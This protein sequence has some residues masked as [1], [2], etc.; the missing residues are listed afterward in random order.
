MTHANEAVLDEY[1]SAWC[2]HDVQRILNCFTDD[3][4]YEDLAFNVINKGHDDIR[5]FLETVFREQK[6]FQ[7]RYRHRFATDTDGAGEWIINTTWSGAFG[8]VDKTGTAVEFTGLS[9]YEFRD[10]KISRCIDCWDS[11]QLMRQ[12]RVLT[13][14]LQALTQDTRRC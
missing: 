9:L 4:V 11:A 10:G 8:G 12:F 1:Y 14:E 5:A 2:T 13:D 3:A 6:D 7:V